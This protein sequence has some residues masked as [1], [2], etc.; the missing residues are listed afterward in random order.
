M[1]LLPFAAAVE[2]PAARPYP[3]TVGSIQGPGR[4]RPMVPTPPRSPTAF[5]VTRGRGSGPWRTSY[6]DVSE[7]RPQ[8]PLPQRLHPL[9]SDITDELQ[10]YYDSPAGPKRSLPCFR[11]R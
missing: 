8:L 3:A 4:C 2:D 7:S 1:R 9:S 10:K 11:G 6:V 5:V